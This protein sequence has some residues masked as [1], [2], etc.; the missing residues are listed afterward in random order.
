MVNLGTF[1][2]TPNASLDDEAVIVQHYTG[3]LYSTNTLFI[4]LF[5]NIRLE[6]VNNAATNCKYQRGGTVRPQSKGAKW[7]GRG[8]SG[9]PQ[10]LDGP[11]PNFYV[12]F[13]WG[14]R[15]LFHM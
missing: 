14:S 1:S 6:Q 9:P 8:G 3:T 4:Y 12:A 2:V 11:P 13:W 7:G 10:N 5:I 15:L